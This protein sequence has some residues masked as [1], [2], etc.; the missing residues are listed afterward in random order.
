MKN[1]VNHWVG[2]ASMSNGSKSPCSAN[3]FSFLYPQMTQFLNRSPF[4]VKVA[5]KLLLSIF[6]PRKKTIVK[7]SI[8]E[9][10]M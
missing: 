5:P 6:K 3:R 4:S 1:C 10:N 2:A 8:M 7:P 9:C